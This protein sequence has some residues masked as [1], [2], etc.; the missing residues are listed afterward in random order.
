LHSFSVEFLD[1]IQPF[2]LLELKVALFGKSVILDDLETD[3]KSRPSRETNTLNIIVII[4]VLQLQMLILI[5]G[6]FFEPHFFFFNPFLHPHKITLN[7]F[8]KVMF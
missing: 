6:I 1:G 3:Q 5:L 7:Q 2:S 4:L 8:L